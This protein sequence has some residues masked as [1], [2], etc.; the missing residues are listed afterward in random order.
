MTND[1]IVE[2]VR[3]LRQELFERCGNDLD[4]F[5][6]FIRTSQA[7]HGERLITSFKKKQSGGTNPLT[8]EAKK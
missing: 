1:P 3:K 8:A 7:Q 2:E 6:E 4:R 5:M